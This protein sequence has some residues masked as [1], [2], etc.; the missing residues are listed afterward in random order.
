MPFAKSLNQVIKSLTPV[1]RGD[2]VYHVASAERINGIQDA[3]RLIVRGDNIVS[4]IN[5]RKKSGDG[6]VIISGEPGGRGGGGGVGFPW[7]ISLQ[8][9]AGIAQVVVAPGTI[10]SV[11]PTNMF[12]TWPIA[13]TG[14]FYVTLDV[15]TDG[16][17][18]TTAVID[19]NSTVP[20]DP[21]GINLNLAPLDLSLLLGV[22]VDKRIFQVAYSLFQAVP[23]EALKTLKTTLT[24]GTPYWDIN[25]TWNITSY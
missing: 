1:R 7:E 5:I 6:Y 23:I 18:P 13:G 14:T 22:I 20:P 11:L 2:S 10:N 19:G 21:V 3:I 9:L 25:Y 16:T 4:G 15:T 24:P 17:K 8:T 12:D